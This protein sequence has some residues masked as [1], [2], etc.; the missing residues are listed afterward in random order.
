MKKIIFSIFLLLLACNFSFSQSGWFWLNTNTNN[1]FSKVTF[2]NEYT[3]FVGSWSSTMH[4]NYII[5]TTNSGMNWYTSFS[6]AGIYDICFINTNTGYAVGYNSNGLILKTVDCGANWYPLSSGATHALNSVYF[7]NEF[8]GYCVGLFGEYL[9]TTNGGASWQRQ[10]F[11]AYDFNDVCFTD[12]LR[13]YFCVYDLQTVHSGI[14]LR[15]T[16][17]GSNLF[18][19]GQQFTA[20]DDFF[21]IYFINQL[22]GFAVGYT[23]RI[24]KTT[25]AGINWMSKLTNSTVRLNSVYFPSDSV[26]YAVGYR[27]LMKTTD[28]GESWV[29]QF[30]GVGIITGESVFFTNN[31]T[32]YV[33]MDYGRILK[34]TTGGGNYIVSI[35]NEINQ[36]PSSFS[37]SQN[38]PNPFNPITKIK[39][40]IAKLSDAK[41]VIYDVVGRE[42]G[43]LINQQLSP[44]TYETEWDVSA[45]PSG[46]YF[47]KLT[48]GE[49]AETKKMVLI[50]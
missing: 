40:H 11:S 16:D 45:Y 3:G 34:T 21:S 27:A 35:G 5:K 18:W 29:N 41:L 32:G 23:G 17:G 9:K 13:G 22:T 47:Y 8:T 24:I 15:T 43:T 38:Y 33:V 14:I 30:S 19:D 46:V 48:A 39:F 42:I 6:S 7:V 49:Y 31:Y 10:I 2:I 28:V 4:D 26:G 36:F 1:S 20:N 37:L 44:G 50:K 25:N 12:N